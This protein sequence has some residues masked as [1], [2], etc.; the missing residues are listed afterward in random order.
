MIKD[1]TR[2]YRNSSTGGLMEKTAKSGDSVELYIT[3]KDIQ[4]VIDR[5]RGWDTLDGILSNL[6]TYFQV[7][8]RTSANDTARKILNC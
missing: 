7:D 6:G 1:V 5:N 2:H 4:K 8:K 3:R